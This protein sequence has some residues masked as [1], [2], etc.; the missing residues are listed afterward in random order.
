M[1]KLLVI[2][3]GGN[4]L[5]K[6]PRYQRVEDQYAAICETARPIVDLIEGGYRTIISHGNGPQVGFI[7][8]RSE[9]AYM[10]EGL[11]FQVP[12]GSGSPGRPGCRPHSLPGAQNATLHERKLFQIVVK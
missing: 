6:D 9:I 4:S 12:A 11:H 1:P 8:R 10:H 3:I 7:L 2:A 5:I